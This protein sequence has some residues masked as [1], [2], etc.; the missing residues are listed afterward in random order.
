[1]L[2]CSPASNVRRNGI[3]KTTTK[4]RRKKMF[5]N[6]KSTIVLMGILSI[7]MLPSGLKADELFFSE[8][9]E[10][11]GYNKALE[12]FNPTVDSIDLALGSYS[13]RIYFNGNAAPSDIFQLTGALSPSETYVIAHPSADTAI[14]NAADILSNL[15]FNGDDAI[16][17]FKGTDII[18]GIGR[19]GEDPGS[20]W[21]SGLAGTQ[22]NTLRRRPEIT[23][24]DMD[25][26]D[27]F[28]PSTEWE[29]FALNTLDG[30]GAHH[31][32]APVPEPATMLILGTGLIALAGF[33][34]IRL[35]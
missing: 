4:E 15:T 30:L 28:Y 26:Y 5:R 10:G 2:L 13:I 11:S 24:G 17:L 27:A 25:P 9:I 29:G 3:F 6:L 31:V 35:R 7:V 21:G 20:E 23:A 8:Y 1:M 18:D 34:R 14:K 33:R 19:I 12:I 32:S 22:D 16:V